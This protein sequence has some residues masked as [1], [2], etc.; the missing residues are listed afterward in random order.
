MKFIMFMFNIQLLLLLFNVGTHIEAQQAVQKSNPQKLYAHYMPWFET[1]ATNGGSWGYHWTLN[2]ANPDTIVDA[3][4]GKRQ[5]ASHFYPLIGPYASSDRDVIEYHLLLLKYSGVDGI[6]IDWYGVAGT[7]GDL[8][9]LKANSDTIV[10]QTLQYGLK[11]GVILEDRFTATVENAQANLGYLRD[12]YFS[13]SN[14]IR[15]GIDNQPLVGVFG[16]ITF[17]QPSQWSQILAAAGQ[18]LQFLS[19]WDNKNAGS[20]ADGE[21]TWIY[22]DDSHPYAPYLEDYYSQRAPALGTVGGVVYPGFYDFYADAGVG[23]SY[24]YIPHNNGQT[25]DTTVALAQQYQGG[26]DFVQIATWNDFGEGTIVE[27]TL[28]FGYQYLRKLQLFTGVGYTDSELDVVH[29]LFL[30]R[31][32]TN[33]SATS[34]LNQASQYLANLDVSS[35]LAIIQSLE[36]TR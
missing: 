16:P 5:I 36:G 15:L 17:T 30:L 7:N 2:Y 12:N 32:S 29:R 10:S 34:Q 11:F 31:K 33:G 35:A 4:T 9:S 14:Y 27:P 3:S 1:P 21:Y 26:L 13:K 8:P 22:Q 24:F 6:L 18:D 28:E 20:N 23:P 19:L 25:L